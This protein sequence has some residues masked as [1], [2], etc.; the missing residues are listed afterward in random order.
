MY[1]ESEWQALV[2]DYVRELNA[3]EIPPD[4]APATLVALQA[5][6]DRLHT[7]AR[8]D[9]CQLKGELLR[10]RDRIKILSKTYYLE[11]R[12]AARTEKEREAL[13]WQRLAAEKYGELPLPEAANVLEAQVMFLDTVVSLVSSKAQRMITLLGSMKLE[14]TIMSLELSGEA[15]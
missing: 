3:L 9:L 15:H 14:S 11:V 12:D 4:P 8:L 7:R 2:E 10:L 13:V 5:G 6:L 1:S